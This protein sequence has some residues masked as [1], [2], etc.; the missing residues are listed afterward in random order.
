MKTLGTLGQ[1]FTGQQSTMVEASPEELQRRA[2]QESIDQL[3]ATSGVVELVPFMLEDLA[4][5]VAAV[6]SAQVTIGNQEQPRG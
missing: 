2:H 4:A 6:R 5:A 3:K 1:L